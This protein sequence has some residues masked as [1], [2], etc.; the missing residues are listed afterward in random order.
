[1]T[2]NYISGTNLAGQLCDGFIIDTVITMIPVSVGSS[3]SMDIRAPQQF[4]MALTAYLVID[5][6]NKLH[7]VSP[8]ALS[9]INLT[10]EFIQQIQQVTVGNAQP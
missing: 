8:A 5:G 4:P 1:M 6:D 9:K 3:N 2:G 7:L 10:D